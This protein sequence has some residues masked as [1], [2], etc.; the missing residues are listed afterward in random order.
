[1]RARDNCVQRILASG[2]R[3]YVY[4]NFRLFSCLN[5]FFTI[6]IKLYD[7]NSNLVLKDCHIIRLYCILYLCNKTICRNVCNKILSMLGEFYFV[8]IY[9]IDRAH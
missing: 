9:T 5:D 8:S 6:F 2:C 1:M 3:V 7:C 4:F